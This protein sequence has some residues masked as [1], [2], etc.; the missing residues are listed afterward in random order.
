MRNPEIVNPLELKSWIDYLASDAM[1]G[2]A[3]GSP[4]MK[5]AAGWLAERFKE[6]G[7]KPAFLTAVICRIIPQQQGKGVLMKKISLG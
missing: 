4:E 5:I 7:L 1:R 2:R 3:N 6:F